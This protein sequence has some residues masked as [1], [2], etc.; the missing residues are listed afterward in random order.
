[1]SAT[2][3]HRIAAASLLLTGFLAAACSRE[4]P[5]APPEKTLPVLNEIG[6]FRLTDQTGREFGR[7]DLLGRA[8][9]AT[10]FFSSCPSVCPAI[11][12]ELRRVDAAFAGDDRLGFLGITVDP[13][14]DTPER[15]AAWAEEQGFPRDRWV[16]LTGPES[17]LA[18]VAEESFL[19]AFRGL[20]HPTRLV[21]VD[22]RGR[23]RG[24]YEGLDDPESVDELIA[25]LP[26]V[27]DEGEAR[28]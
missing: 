7:D 8:W 12:N 24:Y 25:D 27:L 5:P 1:M 15:L 4:G 28:P 2:P 26:A 23:V 19:L 21:L 22:A 3:F 13:A 18:K 10:F 20:A 14:N 17:D 16:F 6:E 9:V 11:M